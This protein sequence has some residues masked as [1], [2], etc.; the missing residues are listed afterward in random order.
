M[1]NIKKYLQ[2]NYDLY[3]FQLTYPFF[4]MYN[5]HDR[6]FDNS[7]RYFIICPLLFWP[8]NISLINNPDLL[9]SGYQFMNG[10]TRVPRVGVHVFMTEK[11]FWTIFE[12]FLSYLVEIFAFALVFHI[13]MPEG[14]GPCSPLLVGKNPQNIFEY[15]KKLSLLWKIP[16]RWFLQ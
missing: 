13:L 12:F 6:Y 1:D 11:V 16:K 9:C 4:F 10:L 3:I 14:R 15:E 7:F 2:R 8:F 5:V